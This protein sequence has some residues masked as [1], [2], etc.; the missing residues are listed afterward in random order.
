LNRNDIYHALIRQY[1]PYKSFKVRLKDQNMMKVTCR[2]IAALSTLLV[3]VY[4]HA[5]CWQEASNVHK[6]DPILLQ[7]VG[8]QES[9]GRTAA[10]GPL[11]PD[12]NRALGVMQINT[13]HL[14]A[15][16]A[17]GISRNDLFDPCTSVMVGAW[18]LRDCINRFGQ[19]WRAVGC[20][21]AGPNSRAFTAMEGYVQQVQKHYEG[22]LRDAIAQLASR[23]SETE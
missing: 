16:K 14:P 3:A 5:S 6:V 8:W 20:Y 18:V 15:L 7:S 13:I 12:G 2:V 21:Y 11:L 19:S 23:E 9:R 17:Q 10:V 4:S 1:H 22:Y